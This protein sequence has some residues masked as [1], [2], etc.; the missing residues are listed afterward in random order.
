M[1]SLAAVALLLPLFTPQAP[2]V[3][4]DRTPPAPPVLH[5]EV[6]LAD[7]QDPVPLAAFGLGCGGFGT[8]APDALRWT[9]SGCTTAGGAH[10]EVQSVGVKLRFP[11]GRELLVAPDGH[12]HLRSGE[13]AG[14]FAHG[15]ELRL[16][17]GTLVRITLAPNAR[18]RVREVE[19]Q[20]GERVIQPWRRGAA[21]TWVGRPGHWAGLRFACCGDGGDL[22]RVIALGPLVVLDRV[23]VAED[24]AAATP[25][26]RLV[27]LTA[28]LLDG[29]ARLPRQQRERD[30]DVRR[31][32]TAVAA[33]ADRG[34]TIFPA[35]AALHR[36]ERDQLRW[37]LRGG[38][39]LALELEG[40]QAP[41]LALFAGEA[42][43]AIVEWT[44]LGQPAAW[45]GN[46]V[47]DGGHGRWHGN[48]MRLPR[49]AADLQPNEVLFERAH[50]LRVIGRLRR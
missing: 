27:V 31:T 45:L 32:V 40:Q 26:E 38:Y 34:A 21:A 24:R 2:P 7:A 19:L 14:P 20:H 13:L 5:P 8:A 33:I 47:A 12:V 3:P 44:L 1:G 37:V 6:V 35:G 43:R 15:L 11:S 10:I 28:P 17:D 4:N 48:G 16:G 18:E 36:A 49:I 39:E 46:P 23:L 41:R 50:A 30:D 25:R 22:Y 9:P 42:P 29:L